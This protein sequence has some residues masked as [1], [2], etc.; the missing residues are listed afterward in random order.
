MLKVVCLLMLMLPGQAH[1]TVQPEG[2]TVIRI[3]SKTSVIVDGREIEGEHYQWKPYRVEGI[4]V[5]VK[6]H[7]FTEKGP[8]RA[9]IILPARE[10]KKIKINQRILGG[11]KMLIL[12]QRTPVKTGKG[13]QATYP[14]YRPWTKD[15][16]RKSRRK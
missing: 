4:E 10:V 6:E 9:V 5:E 3:L 11:K 2:W 15:D 14:T 1:V 16:D 13:F 12:D 7:A 8:E